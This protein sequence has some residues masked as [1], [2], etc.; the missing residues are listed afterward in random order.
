VGRA[1]LLSAR[2]VADPTL[3]VKIFPC[4]D[5]NPMIAIAMLNLVALVLG[6]A[7]DV[8]GAIEQFC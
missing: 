1:G 6:E 2:P 3:N 5:I 7:T 4:Y 8:N